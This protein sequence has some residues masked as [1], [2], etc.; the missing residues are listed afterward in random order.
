VAETDRRTDGDVL[1]N[2]EFAYT[3]KLCLQNYT[4]CKYGCTGSNADSEECAVG[5][6]ETVGVYG[7]D[8]VI[9]AD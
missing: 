7:R 2:C 9:F 6:R 4:E 5:E 1:R 3:R 8:I